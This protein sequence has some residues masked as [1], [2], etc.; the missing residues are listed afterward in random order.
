MT[1]T[2]TTC[3][4]GHSSASCILAWPMTVEQLEDLVSRYATVGYFADLED[5]FTPCDALARSII[6]QAAL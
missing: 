4:A 1:N 5:G 2:Q 6:R 3:P